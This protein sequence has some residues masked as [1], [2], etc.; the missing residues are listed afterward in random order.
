IKEN[1]TGDADGDGVPSRI[2]VVYPMTPVAPKNPASE[3]DQIAADNLFYLWN[4]VYLNAVIRGDFDEALDGTT[5][6]R[7]DLADRMDFVGVNYYFGLTVEGTSSAFLPALSPKSTFNPLSLTPGGE[8]AP[9]FYEMLMFVHD[10]YGLPIVVTENGMSDREGTLASGFLVR[11][12][13][14]LK[15]AMRD[16]A[17]VRG[18]FYWSLMDNY[19]WNHGTSA[20]FFGLFA[21]DPSDPQKTRKKK[22]VAD[23]YRRIST[24][25]G[26]PRDL[27]DA[28]VPP[29]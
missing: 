6:H 26:L 17:D 23:T 24:L 12:L 4:S 2:G 13:Y 10:A 20:Y 27:I 25:N 8:N 21:V 9:G 22:P 3:R 19:E 18:Y 1:D 14:H 5:I 28:H 11:H 15:R 7:D 29:E 16:G